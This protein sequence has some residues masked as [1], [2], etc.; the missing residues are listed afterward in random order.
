VVIVMSGLNRLTGAGDLSYLPS[1]P[2]LHGR[3][4]SFCHFSQVESERSR[5]LCCWAARCLLRTIKRGWF[6]VIWMQSRIKNFVLADLN[7]GD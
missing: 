6:P 3:Q 4:S 5:G 7:V 2:L 1:S